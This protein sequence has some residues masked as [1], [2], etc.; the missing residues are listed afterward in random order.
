MYFFT[1]IAKLDKLRHYS[2][3]NMQAFLTRNGHTCSNQ[4]DGF[5]TS[6]VVKYGHLSL[7]ML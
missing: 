3:F 5:K 2:G 6:T 7:P 4:S 1:Y